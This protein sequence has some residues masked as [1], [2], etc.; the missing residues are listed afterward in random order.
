MTRIDLSAFKEN[1][2]LLATTELLVAED[3][4]LRK[5]ADIFALYLKEIRLDDILEIVSGDVLVA[6]NIDAAVHD[7]LILY[8]ELANNNSGHPEKI[9][10]SSLYQ[11]SRK[12]ALDFIDR[13]TMVSSK[14]REIY[15]S[16]AALLEYEL[17]SLPWIERRKNHKKIMEKLMHFILKH[18]NGKDPFIS[19]S[20]NL[21][22]QKEFVLIP[23]G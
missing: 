4:S 18:F 16:K 17:K 14:V 7:F 15:G 21:P 8:H 23:V 11:S 22:I 5:I 6:L 12:A 20:D 19:R 1:G 2:E 13:K 3:P 9:T 10:T